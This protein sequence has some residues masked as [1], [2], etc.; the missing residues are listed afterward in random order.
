M[1]K[2]PTDLRMSSNPLDNDV[3]KLR[4]TIRYKTLHRE[5]FDTKFRLEN[6]KYSK[7]YQQ[8]QPTFGPVHPK[9]LG[10]TR[11]R[12]KHLYPPE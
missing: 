6:L 11:P 10:V 5:E 3:M 4:D 1:K 7:V 2:I 9:N 8:N 12:D